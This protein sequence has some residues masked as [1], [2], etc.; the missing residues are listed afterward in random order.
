ML[1]R[2]H[3]LQSLNIPELDLQRTLARFTLAGGHVQCAATGDLVLAC[4]DDGSVR[5]VNSTDP[6]ADFFSLKGADNRAVK[7]VALDTAQQ[8]AAVGCSDGYLLIWRLSDRSLVH[9][10]RPMPL[11]NT[12]QSAANPSAS[13]SSSS[14]SSSS[15]AAT[16]VF[17]VAFEPTHGKWLA[18]PGEKGAQVWHGA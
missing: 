18:V 14:S 13:S 16:S 9:N 1:S 7:C 5:M 3:N 10:S 11:L 6:A 4:A 2:D 8:F 17:R 12:F 15:F